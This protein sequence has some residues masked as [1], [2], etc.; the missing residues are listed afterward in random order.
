MGWLLLVGIKGDR[1]KDAEK[2]FESQTNSFMTTIKERYERNETV[3]YGIEGLFNASQKVDPN[4]WEANIENLHV[5]QNF[6]AISWLA[7]IGI[8]SQSEKEAFIQSQKEQMKME[9][10]IWPSDNSPLSFPIVYIYPTSYK[11]LLGYNFAANQQNAD[12]LENSISSKEITST[13][14]LHESREKLKNSE[15]ILFFPIVIGEN[16]P[17]TGWIAVSV[18]FAMILD[19]TN[20]ALELN[21]VRIKVYTG[22]SLSFNSLIYQKNADIDP[23]SNFSITKRYEFAGTLWTFV[24]EKSLP[25]QNL[26]TAYTFFLVLFLSLI[27]IVVG[28]FLYFY[29]LKKSGVIASENSID[30][31]LL[32]NTQYAFIATDTK[33]VITYFNP[34]AERLL[35]YSAAEMIGKQTPAIFHDQDE[36]KVRAEE[37]SKVLSREVK[38]EFEVFVAL[39]EKSQA[40]N[41]RWIYIKKDKT[42][43]Y[44]QLSV[45]VLKNQAGEISGY[46]GVAIDS[47]QISI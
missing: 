42:K 30:K 40:D 7:Y 24:F 45:T 3:L 33:G 1:Q 46:L 36:M 11:D 12:I 15:K 29:Y 26:I 14:V 38:P 23:K 21:G 13:S 28:L 5:D 8:V 31:F 43:I 19:Q 10:S 35:G 22:G 17:V 2:F 16:D 37:L 4:E 39:A 34:A 44:V 9:Y 25:S 27:A 18:D 47:T 41:R 32:A 6:P 20:K